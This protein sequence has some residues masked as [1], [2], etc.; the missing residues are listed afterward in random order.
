M[1]L[2]LSYNN[3]ISLLISRTFL[4]DNIII[5]IAKKQF[6]STRVVNHI[7][8]MRVL[9]IINPSCG[10]EK[11]RE[12][13]R[14][15]ITL[16]SARLHPRISFVH[17]NLGQPSHRRIVTHAADTISVLHN[18][19]LVSKNKRGREEREKKKS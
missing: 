18:A 9:N 19:R 5:K 13:D 6:L 4:L 8:C 2:I 7:T 10:L 11:K 15:F 3:T 17:V 1:K 12:R 16:I 14:N